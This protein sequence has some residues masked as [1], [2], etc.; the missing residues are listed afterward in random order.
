MD[1]KTMVEVTD[2]RDIASA[3]RYLTRVAQACCDTKEVED[4]RP[5]HPAVEFAREVRI[6]AA[7]AER[8]RLRNLPDDVASHIAEKHFI[9]YETSKLIGKALADALESQ[10]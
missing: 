6:E 5:E 8:D 7:K 3:K 10:P 2:E 9:S 1:D 4:V